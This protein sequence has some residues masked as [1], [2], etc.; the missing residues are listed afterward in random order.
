MSTVSECKPK[1]QLVGKDGNAF[2]V[3]GACSAA[4]KKAGWD[5][6][7]CDEFMN[8]AMS[9]NYDHLLQTALQYFDVS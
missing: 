3:L 6:A 8:A 7:K 1:V 4:A 9:G 2:A 5:K